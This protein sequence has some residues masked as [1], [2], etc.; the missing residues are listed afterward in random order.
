MPKVNIDGQ[1]IQAPEGSTLIQACEIAGIEIPRFCYHKRLKI[2]G[3][4][5]MCLVEIDKSPKLVASCAT[6]VSDGMIAHTNTEKVA[7]ARQGVME[8]LLINH[9]L[10]CPVCDQG[11]ECDLQ[12]QAFKY[13]KNFSR[14]HENKRIVKDKYMG[15]LIATHMTRCIHCTRCIRFAADVAGIDEIGTIGRGEDM[16]V[17]TYLAKSITSEL[18]G[19]L[20]DICPVGALTSKPYEFKYRSWE[21]TSI[22]SIDVFDAMGSNIRID[23]KGHEVIR[24]LPELNEEINQE[25]ISDKARFSYD[26]LRYQRLDKPYFRVDGALQEVSWGFALDTLKAKITNTKPDRM[27]AICGQMVDCE[28][29]FALKE[30]FNAIGCDNL[31]CNQNGYSFETRYRGNYLFNTT[32]AGVEKADFCLLIGANVRANA[33]LLGARIGQQVRQS[34]IRVCSI[35]ALSDQTYPIEHLGDNPKILEQI[36][37]AKHSI[38]Q[39]LSQSKNPMLIIGDG[40]LVRDDSLQIQAIAYAIARQYNFI[41]NDWNGFNILHQDASSVGLLDLKFH[42]KNQYES[43]S[44]GQG[45]NIKQILSACQQNQM[46]LVYLLAADKIDM[47]SLGK[48]FVVYQGHHG[49][50]GANRAD[51]ILPATEYTQ[52][53]ATYVNLEGRVQKARRVVQPFGQAKDDR[54]IIIDL[55]Q[56]LSLNL[57]F[58]DL[59]NLQTQMLKQ[60]PIFANIG[61]IV[62]ST[63]H[64]DSV[65]S[66]CFQDEP[67]KNIATNNYYMDNAI[68]RASPTMLACTK[69][70]LGQK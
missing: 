52:K 61:K 46:D 27:A 22:K 51:L 3:N 14:F 60:Y 54:Q 35:G 53:D 48:S 17:S 56:K 67:I 34:K 25:W 47:T 50:A 63:I 32:I 55:A 37:S 44:Q 59:Q 41:R 49:D 24:I 28:S 38:C 30:L 5:R 20:I 2:A 4:C 65:T 21:L 7:Q 16:E 43:Q 15:P 31:A 58:N 18:S 12:D 19:N 36:L 57:G 23:I 62:A 70:I 33:P 68:S 1:N 13:G 10:D 26:G 11:G 9:P 64:F 6:L 39:A 45:K 40:V 42:P 8:F 66:N 29:I 69:F